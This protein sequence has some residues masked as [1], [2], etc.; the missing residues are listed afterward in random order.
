VY[1]GDQRKAVELELYE[2]VGEAA[3]WPERFFDPQNSPHPPGVRAWAACTLA[4]RQQLNNVEQTFRKDDRPD[5]LPRFPSNLEPI[6]KAYGGF[7]GVTSLIAQAGV[8][9][10]MVA[11]S[12]ALTAAATQKWNVVYFCGELDESEI[13]ERRAREMTVH[14]TAVDGVD[15][16]KVVMVGKGQTTFDFCVELIGLDPELPLLV[17]MDS[18]NTIA[19][20]ART[21]Y[22]R[23]LEDYALRAMLARRLSRGAA[24]FLLVSE[25]NKRGNS[26]GEKLEFWSDLAIT[27]SGK[28]DETAV[29]FNISKIR[30]GQWR[31]LGTF[32]R[33]WANCRFYT[34]EQLRRMRQPRLYAVGDDV[35][36]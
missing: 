35:Q 23:T 26:K 22:L 17:V 25:T 29:D 21:D 12:S 14:E 36:F 2:K 27:M 32:E 28:K 1:S 5:E 10:T 31:H 15:F 11:L 33:S 30:R 20:L 6:D 19:T 3:D 16:L 18:I 4:T 24:S 13:I 8:G 34:E 9:K 7:F